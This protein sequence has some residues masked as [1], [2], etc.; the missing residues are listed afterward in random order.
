MFMMFACVVVGGYQN[1]QQEHIMR[2]DAAT[3]TEL[4]FFSNLIAVPALLSHS[5]ISG[6]FAVYL[7][8]LF[9][10][11]FCQSQIFSQT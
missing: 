8:S 2:E 1:S 3:P 11:I 7:Y 5:I 4:M 9:L 10:R 6:E